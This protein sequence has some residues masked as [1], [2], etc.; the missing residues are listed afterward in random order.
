MDPNKVEAVSAWPRPTN[1]LELQN[2]LGLA[3]YYRRFL[4]GYAKLAAPLTMLAK[5]N[6]KFNWSD[7]CKRSF[8]E[9]KERLIST[10]VLAL[11]SSTVRFVIYSDDSRNGLGCV[12]MQNGRVIT[13][14]SKQ[15]KRV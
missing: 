13:Y 1:I 12:L 3:G 4:E 9:L 10:L 7:I 8:K 6:S 15:L 2:F 14:A 11:P 5:E